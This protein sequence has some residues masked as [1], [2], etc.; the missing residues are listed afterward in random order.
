MFMLWFD[1]MLGSQS[2]VSSSLG[3]ESRPLSRAVPELW[4]IWSSE[5]DKDQDQ[6]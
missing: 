3:Q 1:F 4:R 5:W 6:G 2:N